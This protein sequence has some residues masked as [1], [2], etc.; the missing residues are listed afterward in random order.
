MP[1]DWFRNERW[2][3]EIERFFYEKLNRSRSQRAQYLRI[4][5]YSL[6]KTEPLVALRLLDEYFATGD[7]FFVAAAYSDRATALETLGLVTE[8]IEAHRLSIEWSAAHP[9]YQTVSRLE[10]PF[11]IATSGQQEYYDLAVQL[12]QTPDLK[13]VFPVEM[14]LY[15]ASLAIIFSKRGEPSNA[16]KFAESALEAAGTR[17][18]TLRGHSGLGLVG[19]RFPNEVKRMER[20]VAAKGERESGKGGW[21]AKLGFT[22]R[23]Q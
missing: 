20:L 21:M 5:A 13:L 16:L 10:L 17:K 22:Q 15:A 19:N 6:T 11:L 12:L 9:G 1:K 14:F 7:T 3:A 18:S 8:A 4:Q 23:I 2:S